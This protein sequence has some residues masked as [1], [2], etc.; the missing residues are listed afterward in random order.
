MASTAVL[1]HVIPLEYLVAGTV[2][3]TGSALTVLAQTSPESITPWVSAGGSAAAVSGL[4]YM[5]K[6]LVDGSL[7]AAPIADL[8][9]RADERDR[10]FLHLVAEQEDRWG[11][12]VRDGA[13]REDVYRDIILAR[14]KDGT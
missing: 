10:E 1:T 5:A 9:R 6:K 8:L 4:V 7:V 3:L 13:E 12:V 2:T 14:R 11:R